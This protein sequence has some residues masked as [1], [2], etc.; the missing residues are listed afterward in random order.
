MPALRTV[1]QLQVI[2]MSTKYTSK[3]RKLALLFVLVSCSLFSQ[4]KR[5]TIKQ[6]GAV[7]VKFRWNRKVSCHHLISNEF[8]SQIVFQMEVILLGQIENQTEMSFLCKRRD[9]V[10]IIMTHA[11]FT[12]TARG[13]R[14]MQ[15]GIKPKRK[16][17]YCLWT[18]VLY[19]RF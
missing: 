2:Y 4:W 8:F 11:Y 13:Q 18:L 15:T 3:K 5:R 10:L 9:E 12:I 14:E 19:E 7:E 16:F 17:W 1:T 6:F